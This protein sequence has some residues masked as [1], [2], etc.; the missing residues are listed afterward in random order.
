MLMK[1]VYTVFALMCLAGFLKAQQLP[2][3]SQYMVNDF[4][5]N[6]AVAGKNPYWEAKS[7]N[8]YQWIGVTDAPRT[9]MLSVHGPGKSRKVGMG[10][11]LFTDITGPTRRTGIYGTYS[12]HARI[13]EKMKLAL[14]LSAGLLQFMVDGSKITLRDPADL[15]ISSGLQ[16]V[17]LPDFG[18]GFY[19]YTDNWYVGGAVPQVMQ[20]R[21]RFFDYTSSTT[22]VLSRHYFATAGYKIRIGEDFIIEPSTVVKW[23]KPVPVQFDLGAR[24][25][26]KEKVWIGGAYRNLDAASAMIGYVYRE[27]LLFGYSFDFTTTNLKNYSSG[28]HEIMIGIRFNEIKEATTKPMVE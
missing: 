12:Y 10:G 22:S 18:A 17:L 11:Y 23:V 6:P 1:K 2:H 26:Y 20:N 28:T 8:R 15:V 27:N 7:N 21:I 3:F 14:G 13:N 25:I 24:F 16:S 5:L 9:Y 19:L 4:A